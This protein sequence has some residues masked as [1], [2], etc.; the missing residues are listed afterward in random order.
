MIVAVLGIPYLIKPVVI[1][2]TFFLNVFL[3]IDHKGG[4]LCS[5]CP[6]YSF[7]TWFLRLV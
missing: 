7:Q 5:I 3:Y 2:P 4:Y 6:L 1:G